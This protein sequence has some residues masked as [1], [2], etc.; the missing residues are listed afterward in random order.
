MNQAPQS[1]ILTEQ[2]RRDLLSQVVSPAV[3]REGVDQAYRLLG[4][5]HGSRLN[6][7]VSSVIH[8][9]QQKRRCFLQEQ[10][11]NLS[12]ITSQGVRE[13]GVRHRARGMSK[14]KGV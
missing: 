10:G 1:V 8:V 5:Y 6:E 3:V 9:L 7:M 11:R 12:V 13:G 2:Q 4:I 14:R